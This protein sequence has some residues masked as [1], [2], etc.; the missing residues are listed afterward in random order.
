[1]ENATSIFG[2]RAILEAI[3]AGKEIEKLY[4]LQDLKGDL[5]SQ[6][7]KSIAENKLPISYVPI[8][9]L[10]KLSKNQNHQGAV[11]KI[12]IVKI[13]DLNKTI[14]ILLNK[15]SPALVLLLD[16]I[17]DVRNFGAILRTA[18]CTGVDAVVFPK[19]GNAPINAETV[20]TSAGAAFNLP[21]CRVDHSLD[22]IYAFQQSGFKTIA[23]TEKTET[24][25]YDLTFSEPTLLIMGSE[26]KGISNSILKIVDAKGKLPILG[27]IESLNVSVACGVALYE[28]LRQRSSQI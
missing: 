8:E 22:A 6:L 25:F 10:N 13:A 7:K 23:V 11:A 21:L 2:I 15:T 20:K 26:E 19:Q 27:K 14:E 4:L 9:K 1:M 5:A 16:Q 17:T 24:L 28:V 3:K 12:S 18:E